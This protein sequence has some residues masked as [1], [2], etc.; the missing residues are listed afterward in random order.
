MN[1]TYEHDKR[2]NIYGSGTDIKRA[3]LFLDKQFSKIDLSKNNEYDMRIMLQSIIDG[4]KLKADI[5]FNGNRVW[6]LKRIIRDFKRALKSK[7]CLVSEYGSGEWN[8]TNYLYEFL[9]LACGSI[10]HY[11]KYGWIGT[12]PEKID[13]KNFF[14]R[15]E[16]GRKVVDDI[17]GWK[18]DAHRILLEIMQIINKDG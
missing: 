11:N 6:S 7:P 4:N 1:E 16:F 10:A 5:L 12:Y 18:S 17:P 2:I 13:L 3:I 9:H 14:Y 15:N 8:M